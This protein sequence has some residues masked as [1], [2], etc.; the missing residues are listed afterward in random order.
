VHSIKGENSME[1][2]LSR[3]GAPQQI[4]TAITPVAS[5]APLGLSMLALTTAI[6]GCF[7]TGFIIPFEDPSIRPAIGVVLLIGGIILV[8]AGMWDFRKNYMMTATTFTSYG[9]FLMALGVIFI[10]GLGIQPALGT[11]T[12]LF[13]G[14]LF[15]CWTIFLGVLCLGT[16]RTN[17]SLASTLVVLF[18][19]YLLLTI[20]ELAGGNIVLTKVGGWLAIACALIAWLASIA[21]I[22]SSAMRNEAFRIPFGNRIAVVE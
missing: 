5:P 8:L 6:L 16:M 10:P 4:E 19:A 2:N 20:G 17:T 13:L 22:M 12:H 15:L 1:K 18:L 14:L 21:S 3:A 9:G 11:G 7:Y